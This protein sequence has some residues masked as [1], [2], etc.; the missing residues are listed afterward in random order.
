MSVCG[1]MEPGGANKMHSSTYSTSGSI[2]GTIPNASKPKLIHSGVNA[3]GNKYRTYDNG[4]YGYSNPK[5]CADP[6]N[7]CG[8]EYKTEFWAPNGNDGD[9]H[10]RDAH[11]G[12]RWHDYPDGTRKV[13][14]FDPPRSHN[15]GTLF[16][17]IYT[18]Y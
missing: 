13:T 1:G 14:Q 16:V 5:K 12:Y 11:K 8:K 10:F 3:H 17:C 15:Q 2:F 18:R 4:A 6:P 9:K 7:G